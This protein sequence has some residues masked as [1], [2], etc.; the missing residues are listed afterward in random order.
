[1]P[2]SW[3]AFTCEEA[4]EPRRP[5]CRK[6]D[7][8]G[9][10]VHSGDLDWLRSHW[11]NA[12]ELGYTLYFLIV[13]GF[14]GVLLVALGAYFSWEV[15]THRQR[16]SWSERT[17]RAR[18]MLALSGLLFAWLLFIPLRMIWV[19][20]VGAI[21]GSY[22]SNG[23]WGAATLTMQPDGTFVEAWRFR[24]EY[25]GKSEGEGLTRGT[26]RNAGR[27]WLTRD[28]ELETFRGLAEYSRGHA[29][30]ITRA[31]VMGYGGVTSIEV[32]AGSD[33]VFHK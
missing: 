9:A 3:R 7:F 11:E 32:D 20:R 26:W 27:D 5:T 14:G 2:A 12:L 31:N 25:N 22:T 29:V 6:P 24:N 8:T 18:L 13:F 23:V 17:R 28:I 19:T 16:P 15:V 21:A 4:Q 30:G 10:S 1:V 33:I